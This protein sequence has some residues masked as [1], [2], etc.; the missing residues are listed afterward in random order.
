LLG[1]QPPLPFSASVYQ[2]LLALDE[3][4]VANTAK[5]Y[6]A[7]HLLAELFDDVFIPALQYANQ[8]HQQGKLDDARWQYVHDAL[9]ELIVDLQEEAALVA[10]KVQ[11]SE[12]KAAAKE[13]AA[14]AAPAAEKTDD[15]PTAVAVIE[16]PAGK[17]LC[18][19][20]RDISDELAGQ[21]LAVLLMAEGYTVEV[22]AAR[23]ATGRDTSKES[24]TRESVNE[25]P[26]VIWIS[27]LPPLADAR[28]RELCRIWTQRHPRSVIN[29]G[30]WR[31]TLHS[32]SI[33]LLKRA[34]AQDI[35][36]TLR[37]AVMFTNQLL[38]PVK[39]EQPPIEAVNTTT[40]SDSATVKVPTLAG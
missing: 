24:S 31:E 15:A 2:R 1:D 9:R 34:G 22:L 33:S 27:A 35:A 10:T 16:K 12:D 3:D 6:L 17:I 14:T 20:A 32:R 11:A 40:L 4:E 8:D 28:T 5:K 37:E 23:E 36:T 18:L 38:R 25:Q 19:A 7:D 29:A 30:L 13:T 21:M 26:R 39:I